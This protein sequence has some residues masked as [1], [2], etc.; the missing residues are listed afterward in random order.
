M[1]IVAL[2]IR[3]LD[4]GISGDGRI[5]YMV[6]ICY[7]ISGSNINCI[8]SQMTAVQIG[9]HVILLRRNYFRCRIAIPTA[10]VKMRCR[11]RVDSIG[12]FI[13]SFC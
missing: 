12:D 2:H 1:A 8:A 3:G 11:A 13:E 10:Y 7:V 6:P 9:P 5:V 4:T